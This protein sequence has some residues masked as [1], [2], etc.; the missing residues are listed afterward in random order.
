MHVTV[1]C[2]GKG[3]RLGADR[4]KCLVEVAGRPFIEHKL[5]Q[6]RQQGATAFQLAV[7]PYGADFAYLGLTMILDLQTGITG[8]RDWLKGWWTMGDALFTDPPE[9]WARKSSPLYLVKKAGGNVG[10]LYEDCGLYRGTN[11]NRILHVPGR[12]Y[13]IN[14]PEDL[15]DTRA[16]MD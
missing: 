1:L 13:T 14:T 10:G 7:G 2:G 15:E 6:L 11:W 3:T 16:A 12:M 9:I 4:P 8:C 5:D